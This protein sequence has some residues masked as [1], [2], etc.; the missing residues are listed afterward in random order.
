ML[1]EKQAHLCISVTWRASL[2]FSS[3]SCRVLFWWRTFIMML[4]T[5]RRLKRSARLTWNVHMSM[6]LQANFHQYYSQS[7][8][9]WFVYVWQCCG[10]QAG[11]DSIRMISKRWLSKHTVVF[12]SLYFIFL[13]Q[14]TSCSG[15]FSLSIS[16]S[17]LVTAVVGR[18]RPVPTTN[19]HIPGKSSTCSII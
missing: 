3:I 11:C 1:D 9:F 10:T 2:L 18:S 12:P 14:P 13:K 17:P 5:T 6:M 8:S 16:L 19:N 15:T 4:K 7:K